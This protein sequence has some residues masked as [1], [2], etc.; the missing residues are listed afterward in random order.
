MYHNNYMQKGYKKE[1]LLTRRG[2]RKEEK[3]IT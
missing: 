3:K 1:V 2:R